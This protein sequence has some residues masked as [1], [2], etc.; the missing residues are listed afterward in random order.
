M[1]SRWRGIVA[2]ALMAGAAVLPARA[3]AEQGLV[4]GPCPAEARAAGAECAN[5]AVPR[6]YARPEGPRIEL[7]I[8]RM[9][10]TDPA[11]RRGILFGLNGGPGADALGFW[12]VWNTRIPAAIPA[13]F[14]Q[15]AV[16]P[17]GL[18]WSTPLRCGSGGSL[19]VPGIIGAVAGLPTGELRACEAED[20]GYPATI[21]TES[22]ARDLDQVRQ[23]L[24][25]DRIN[26]LGLSYGTYVGAVYST[27][28]PERVDKLVLD[29]GAHPG[30]VWTEQFARQLT[31][32][33]ARMAD[34]FD[35]IAANDNAFGLGDT[36]AE[37]ATEWRRQVLAQGG[38]VLASLDPR[39]GASPGPLGDLVGD[40]PPQEQL[41]RLANLAVL[42][43]NPIPGPSPTAAAT[44]LV[45][46]ARYLW[47][48]L[49]QGIRDYRDDPGRT[50]YLTAIRQLIT[51][52]D[53]ATLWTYQAVVCNE[54]G[55]PLDPAGVTA[56]LGGLLTGTGIADFGA[57][58]WRSGVTCAAWPRS[59][60]PVRIDGAGLAVRPLLLQNDRDPQT[61]AE[62]GIALA[63]ALDARLLRTPG[64]DHGALGRRNPIVDDAVLRYLRTGEITVTQAPEAP[65]TTAIPPAEP[66]R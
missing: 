65:I 22:V 32:R 12:T 62:G 64:G 51:M 57:A 28:F 43:S 31:A 15:I 26:L 19:S 55:R 16:Q 59:A 52:D 45:L 66:P 38:G 4:W 1:H 36:R 5:I 3:A 25:V 47:P 21:T 48:Y 42:L 24:G 23:A 14:D 20:P 41:G 9:R 60:T 27:L 61:P 30:W 6:D 40:R 49:A 18:R 35:W 10:A 11:R 37:I 46:G 2:V 39:L 17:R 7:T 63:A 29:S 13:E 53:P 58:L 8:S 33:S 54:G 44:H 34:L 50:E 56:A